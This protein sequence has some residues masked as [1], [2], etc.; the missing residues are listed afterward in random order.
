[1]SR[2]TQSLRTTRTQRGLCGAIAIKLLKWKRILVANS[3]RKTK[4]LTVILEMLKNVSWKMAGEGGRG[5][6]F[7]S[8]KVKV[9]IN[10]F[11]N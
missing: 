11:N 1:M 8:G 10:Y 3:E 2:A 7:G 5:S 4:S 9:T 6:R